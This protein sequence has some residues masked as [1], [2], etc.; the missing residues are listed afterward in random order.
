MLLCY[1]YCEK[2]VRIWTL[3]AVQNMIRSRK[4]NLATVILTAAIDFAFGKKVLTLAKASG[5]NTTFRADKSRQS[6]YIERVE[7]FNVES[8]R[9]KEIY[10]YST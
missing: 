8:K 9:T 10:I 4:Y 7:F 3:H 2:S 1:Q 5:S 6:K